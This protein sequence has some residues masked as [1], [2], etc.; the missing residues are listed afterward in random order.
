MENPRRA[1][2]IA[3]LALAASCARTVPNHDDRV[4]TSPP[5]AKMS[6]TDLA[7]AFEKDAPGAKR[8]YWGQVVEV[9]DPIATVN[10]DNPLQPYLLFKTPGPVYIEGHLHDDRAAAILEKVVEGERLTLKCL[11]EGVQT[12]SS[13]TAVVLKSCVK[14]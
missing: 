10:K 11:C 3:A 13:R 14:P 7:S 5:A 9:T 4:I 2:L 6:A 12:T 1:V 8:Q